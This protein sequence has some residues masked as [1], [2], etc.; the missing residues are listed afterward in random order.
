M[1]RFEDQRRRLCGGAAL[2]LRFSPFL[3]GRPNWRLAKWADAEIGAC[4][5]WEWREAPKARVGS[6]AK[7]RKPELGV[8]RSAESPSWEWREAPKD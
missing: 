5:S 7:R 6:G 8:A 4:P 1:L 2:S 3:A